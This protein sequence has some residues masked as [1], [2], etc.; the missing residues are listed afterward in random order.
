MIN[1][2]IDDRYKIEKILSTRGGF[3]DIYLGLDQKTGKKISIKYPEIKN[4]KFV[5]NSLQML[6]I[7]N[8]MEKEAH[9][10]SIFSKHEM[11]KFVDLV[12]H[13]GK[14]VL[15]YEYIEG[16]TLKDL[17]DQ[18]NNSL[19]LKLLKKSVKLLKK[20]HKDGYYHGD[21]KPENFIYSK[22]NGLKLIDLGSFNK[23][24]GKRDNLIKVTDG[25]SPIELYSEKTIID[26]RADYYSLFSTFYYLL[27][28]NKLKKA[29]ERFFHEELE[30]N[31]IKD[32]R[33]R[34]LFVKMLKV[35]QIDR[36]LSC[37][38]LEILDE[39]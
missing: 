18:L 20:I 32:K 28:N 23:I 29:T 2:T 13:D 7:N 21:I 9:A 37:K 1:Q 10:V 8:L 6:E 38:E 11:M 35:N 30:F 22:K 27:E 15:I 12:E 34:Q 36:S 17:K 5:K 25:F 24:G 16:K 4:E 19:K 31:I 39:I 3:S 33:L 26:E 14:K